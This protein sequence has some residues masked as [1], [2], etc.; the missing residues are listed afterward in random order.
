MVKRG[1]LAVAG[2]LAL[3]VAG[4][5]LYVRLQ[6]PDPAVDGAPGPLAF[7]RPLE[8]GADGPLPPA[9]GEAG[10]WEGLA[11]RGILDAGE[12]RL[13]RAIIAQEDGAEAAYGLGD[14]LDGGA[15]VDDI[16]PDRVILL[17]DGRY[18]TLRLEAA[19]A[20]AGDPPASEGRRMLLALRD[21]LFAGPDK[22]LALLDAR[23]VLRDGH[24][25]GYRVFPPEVPEF[26]DLLG[27]SPGDV[28]T[29]IGD[30]RLESGRDLQVALATLVTGSR[31]E[32]TVLR[33][34]IPERL[35][36]GVP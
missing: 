20:A 14:R 31:F 2:V 15:V 28:V 13:A 30:I 1:G 10:G 5:S 27:L 4:V 3:V 9:A 24:Q 21:A 32:I 36:M 35:V 17:R 7:A 23:P 33:N 16:L 19:G 26:L 34:G 11:L 6:A 12:P 8:A 25:I 18:R 22:V 29:A